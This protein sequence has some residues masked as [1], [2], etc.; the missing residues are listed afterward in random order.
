MTRAPTE[1]E[2]RV[3]KALYEH[4]WQSLPNSEPFGD[5][6]KDYW[7]SEARAAIRAMHTPTTE[8]LL[9]YNSF[10][11]QI[12]NWHVMIDAASPQEE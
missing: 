11:T 10:L 12:E 6:C 1:M 4:E 8:M 2:L 5:G 7:V 3:A 9:G